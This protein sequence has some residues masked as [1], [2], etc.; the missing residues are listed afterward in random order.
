MKRKILV[1]AMLTLYLIG[2]SSSNT[3]TFK[4][5]DNFKT[6][7][8]LKLPK[9]SEKET[10]DKEFIDSTLSV[11]QKTT[12][13]TY[14]DTEDNFIISPISLYYALAMCMNGSEDISE[15]QELMN[16]EDI[17][18]INQ[19]LE[20]HFRNTYTNEKNAKLQIANSIWVDNKYTI[21][22]SYIDLLKQYYY[23][24]MYSVNF[25]SD[26]T[27]QN[28]T[29]WVNH[30]T[31]GLLNKTIE[32]YDYLKNNQTMMSLFNTLYFKCDWLNKDTINKDE[33]L[34]LF[35]GTKSTTE[36][37]YIAKKAYGSSYETDKYAI[38]QDG[39]EGGNKIY[40]ILPND[41]ILLDE[42]I[43]STETMSE[44]INLM[45]T[46]DLWE[47]YIVGY[48]VPE[49]DITYNIDFTKQFPKYDFDVSNIEYTKMIEETKLS[50]DKVIQDTRLILNREGVEATSV[51]Q[52]DLLP[53]APPRENYRAYYLNRPFMYVITDSNNIPLFSGV[54][55]TL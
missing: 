13:Q 32:N 41:N 16:F 14:V 55:K 8:Q 33:I 5:T 42:I 27:I 34:D 28:I 20:K 29:D 15:Y 21:K 24:D 46:S 45:T 4:Q 3:I 48:C 44:V 18:I 49:F 1:L 17:N 52:T 26:E 22:E 39:F 53:S 10:L 54:I 19:N 31:R 2:C 40:Y 12:M 47:E 38:I 6:L 30:Y 36:E 50:I 25:A 9:S 37:L 51:T 7:N 43:K 11:F 23:V 35:Y